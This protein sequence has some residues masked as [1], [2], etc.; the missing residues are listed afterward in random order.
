MF[1]A[2]MRGVSGGI[3]GSFRGVFGVL[4]MYGVLLGSLIIMT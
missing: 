1:R 3:L 2:F 4:R